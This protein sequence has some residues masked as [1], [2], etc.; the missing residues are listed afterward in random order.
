MSKDPWKKA[1]ELSRIRQDQLRAARG[2][3]EQ[4]YQPPRV[5]S[6]WSFSLVVSLILVLLIAGA[7]VAYFTRALWWP[8]ASGH[9]PEQ[10]T[11]AVEEAAPE[12]R[13]SIDWHAL[14]KG[15]GANLKQFTS[16]LDFV[17]QV[18]EWGAQDKLKLISTGEGRWRL[19]APGVKVYVQDGLIWTYEL[20][21]SKIYASECW[22]PWWPELRKA[23]LVP[24]YTWEDMTGDPDFPPGHAEQRMRR[25]PSTRV[26]EGWVYPVFILHFDYGKLSELEAAVDYGVSELAVPEES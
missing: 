24:E 3:P 6:R 18:E 1:H 21:L 20:E 26:R 15:L 11:E 16:Y 23:G 13:P 9:L 7:V 19:T 4:L 10:V 25:T 12:L 14:D 2:K 17:S 22:E 5:R 8:Q